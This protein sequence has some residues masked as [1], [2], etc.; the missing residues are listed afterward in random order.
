ML[1][2]ILALHVKVYSLLD[3]SFIFS[4]KDKHIVTSKYQ[5]SIYSTK[6]QIF[7]L[8]R[9][10]NDCSLPTIHNTTQSSTNGKSI[11]RSLNIIKPCKIAP[12]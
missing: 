4:I 12:Q 7:Q 3:F 9:I 11:E 2:K 8:F 1:S 5:Y 10:L 6:S